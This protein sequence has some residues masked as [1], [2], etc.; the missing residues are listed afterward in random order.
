VGT[1]KLA[2]LRETYPNAGRPWSED[3]DRRLKEMFEDDVPLKALCKEFGR[4]S[5][6]IRSRLVK[7]GLVEDTFRRPEES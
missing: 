4:K 7:L 2:K 1:G 5:G 3:D 6:A